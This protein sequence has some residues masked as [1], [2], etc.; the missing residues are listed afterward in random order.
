MRYAA[1]RAF[2]RKKLGQSA[3][4]RRSPDQSHWLRAVR[5]AWRL[6]RALGHAFVGHPNIPDVCQHV[7]VPW[8]DRGAAGT[9]CSMDP[10]DKLASLQ[11]GDVAAAYRDG[12][13][14]AQW[15]RH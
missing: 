15:R 8:I 5:A 9:L 12:A 3:E 13:I 10:V 4:A 6:R 2:K 14:T 1:G 7:A 11:S